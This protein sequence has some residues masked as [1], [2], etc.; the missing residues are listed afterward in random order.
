MHNPERRTLVPVQMQLSRVIV[1]EINDQQAI[2]LKEVD[3]GR[4][5]PIL[6]G[7]FEATIINRRLLEDPPHRPL[8]HDL[9]RMI[10]QSMGGEPMEVVI[11]EIRDHTY[12]AVLK[13]SQKDQVLE[14]DCRPSDAVALAVH[15]NPPLPIYV[16][17]DVLNEVS[18]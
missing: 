15:Y 4:T 7:E 1:S 13:I 9:L 18:G 12:Y 14:I 5:F 16:A 8:T 17:E 3:G 11:T 6:I 10:I 2:Y